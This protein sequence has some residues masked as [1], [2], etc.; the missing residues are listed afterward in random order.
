MYSNSVIN[1]LWKQPNCSPMKYYST[2]KRNKV[3]IHATWMNLSDH[4]R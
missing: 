2:V 3:L 4:A 1:K